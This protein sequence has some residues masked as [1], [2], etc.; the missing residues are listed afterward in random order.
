M[1]RLTTFD[2][3]R[4]GELLAAFVEPI[5]KQTVKDAVRE[6]LREEGLTADARDRSAEQPQP[7][8]PDSG[9]PMVTKLVFLL[10]VVAV[11]YVASRKR[12]DVTERLPAT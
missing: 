10:V 2:T 6:V 8:E 5:L 9:H 3:A 4:A 12:D 1:K 7:H 11:G